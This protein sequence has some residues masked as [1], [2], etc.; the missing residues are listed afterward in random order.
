M[1]VLSFTLWLWISRSAMTQWSARSLFS[2]F[3]EVIFSKEST[4][5]LTVSSSNAKTT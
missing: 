5:L 2:S 4:L 3:R 1:A